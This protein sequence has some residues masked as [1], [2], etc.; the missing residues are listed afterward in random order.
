MEEYQGRTELSHDGLIRG[1]L[2]LLI[3]N[4]R[5]SDDGM[6]MCAVQGDAGYAETA[7]EL[8]VSAPF[9]HDAH[10]WKVALAVMLVLL[11]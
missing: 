11:L 5:P 2:D 9:F 6:Y 1:S 8:E 4:V 3:A 10:P 7:V